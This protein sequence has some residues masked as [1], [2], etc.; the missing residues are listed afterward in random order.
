M[1]GA[2]LLLDIA[3]GDRHLLVLAQVL[4]P[5]FYQEDLG[6]EVWPGGIDEE[7]PLQ[8]AVAQADAAD[9]AHRGGESLVPYPNLDLALPCN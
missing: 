8:G 9:V 6:V 4:G 7:P 2:G 5:R 3:I 1:E